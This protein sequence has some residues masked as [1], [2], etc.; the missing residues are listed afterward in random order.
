MANDFE[1]QNGLP[2]VCYYDLASRGAE[3]CS[4]GSIY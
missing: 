1:D 4:M 2:C 3:Y